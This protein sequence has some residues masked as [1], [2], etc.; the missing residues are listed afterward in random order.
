MK[1]TNNAKWA[2]VAPLQCTTTRATYLNADTE[3]PCPK[4]NRTGV[5]TQRHKPPTS[6]SAGKPVL[7]RCQTDLP[8]HSGDSCLCRQQSHSCTRKHKERT[9]YQMSAQHT[10]QHKA[11]NSTPHKKINSA[12]RVGGMS[13]KALKSAAASRLRSLHRRV[14]APLI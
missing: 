6:N 14:G 9:F 3:T 10:N 8:A 1:L 13:R 5:L 12:Y 4:I 11:I 2:G 7:P